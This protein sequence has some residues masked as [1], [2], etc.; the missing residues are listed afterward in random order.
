MKGIFLK[1]AETSR[2]NDLSNF[3]PVSILT[4]FSKK[5]EKVSKKII[6]ASTNNHLTLFASTYRESITRMDCRSR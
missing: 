5:C 2:K 1:D 4:T 3:T 6:D